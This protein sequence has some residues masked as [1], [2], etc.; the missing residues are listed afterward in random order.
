MKTDLNMNGKDEYCSILKCNQKKTEIQSSQPKRMKLQEFECKICNATFDIN[1]DLNR[2]I[3]TVHE[4]YKPFNCKYCNSRF[5]T[6]KNQRTH[7]ST[8][9]KEKK[10]FKCLSCEGIFFQESH[11]ESHVLLFHTEKNISDTGNF[12][13]VK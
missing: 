11:L 4:G 10:K 2:H 8:V 7:V 3:S 6:I 12:L 9:H 5:T 13:R 1:R